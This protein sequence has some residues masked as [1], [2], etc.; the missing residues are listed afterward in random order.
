MKW[1]LDHILWITGVFAAILII[2]PVIAIIAG[3]FNAVV[4]IM[5]VP[6][7]AITVILAILGWKE[8]NKK[9]RGKKSIDLH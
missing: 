2:L 5:I 9:K 6:I 1:L 4:I 7:T 3:E 8:H